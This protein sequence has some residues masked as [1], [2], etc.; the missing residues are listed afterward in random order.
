M[1]YLAIA[2]LIPSMAFLILALYAMYWANKFFQDWD[3]QWAL[4]N[5][6]DDPCPNTCDVIGDLAA[7]TK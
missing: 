7:K 3:Q 5:L 2:I 6:G 4:D 1:I